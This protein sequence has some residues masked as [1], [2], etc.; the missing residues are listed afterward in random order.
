VQAEVFGGRGESDVRGGRVVA[1]QQG[2]DVGGPG[3][4]EVDRLGVVV[5]KEQVP[6][7]VVEGVVD[8]ALPLEGVGVGEGPWEW[9][10]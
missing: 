10:V 7:F 5:G 9:S 6:D 8:G 4:E 3:L 2:G 1:G